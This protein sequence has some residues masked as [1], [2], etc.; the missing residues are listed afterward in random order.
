[1]DRIGCVR[2]FW[3]GGHSSARLRVIAK[4][5][6]NPISRDD[7]GLRGWRTADV[8]VGTRI[9]YL[10]VWVRRGLLWSVPSCSPMPTHGTHR[11]CGHGEESGSAAAYQLKQASSPSRTAGLGVSGS[12]RASRSTTICPRH[13]LTSSLR[14]VAKS[15]GSCFQ[16]ASCWPSCSFSCAA[17]ASV[18]AP[19]TGSDACWLSA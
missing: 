13:T 12:T 8:V 5:P 19:P 17:S 7:G 1:M 6:P 16:S 10:L 15:S 14:S 4:L 11:A 9:I 3:K 18:S 2:Q